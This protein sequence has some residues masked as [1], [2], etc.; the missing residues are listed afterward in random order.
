MVNGSILRI[1]IFVAKINFMKKQNIISYLFIIVGII[2][3]I[4]VLTKT[5][6]K[7]NKVIKSTQ[8]P[9]QLDD[10]TSK[11]TSIK[12]GEFL[13]TPKSRK[14]ESGEFEIQ[15]IKKTNKFIFDRYDDR[16]FYRESEKDKKYITLNINIKSIDK[17][18]EL[19]VFELF[20]LNNGKMVYA[21]D[22]I[23]RFYKWNDYGSYLGNYADYAND[24]THS[25]SIK[26]SLGCEYDLK[27]QNDTLLI[28][29][30]KN[31]HS[32]RAYNQFETPEISYLN[33]GVITVDKTTN[34][35]LSNYSLVAIL[36]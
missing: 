27:L 16:Y 6:N 36:K 23:Y 1:D 4:N 31:R 32:K 30:S 33:D 24:F 7:S 14:F 20:C 29:Q 26:F 22:F 12:L 11:S 17:N 21:G 18:P 25:N 34:V 19:P 10:S 13:S 8:L 3:V 15:N 5:Q 9:I 35:Q 28:L 2:F